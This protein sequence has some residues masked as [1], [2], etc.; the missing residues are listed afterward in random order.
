MCL[1]S[2]DKKSI[3]I[4]RRCKGEVKQKDKFEFFGDMENKFKVFFGTVVKAG[5]VII[6]VFTDIKINRSY[7]LQFMIFKSLITIEMNQFWSKL[8]I[9]WKLNKIRFLDFITRD[10][11]EKDWNIVKMEQQTNFGFHKRNWAWNR[12]N[13]KLMQSDQL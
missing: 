5:E 9:R 4:C 7:D 11:C 1:S 2:I 12:L 3:T 13:M 6:L 10:C 8:K